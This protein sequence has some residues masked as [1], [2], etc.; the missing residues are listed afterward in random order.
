MNLTSYTEDIKVHLSSLGISGV[1]VVDGPLEFALNTQNAK[2]FMYVHEGT[3]EV[4]RHSNE[5]KYDM[6]IQWT[7]G[8]HLE[9]G[10]RQGENQHLA[11]ARQYLSRIWYSLSGLRIGKFQLMRQSW[12]R[13][14][15]DD[16]SAVVYEISLLHETTE[17][18]ACK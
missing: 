14:L 2:T 17:Y 15:T 9:K 5:K 12:R 1:T 18:E 16:P 4:E 13:V 6:V 10:A 11:Q 8:L 7:I 3:G